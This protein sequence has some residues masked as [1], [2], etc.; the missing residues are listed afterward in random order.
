MSRILRPLLVIAI[1]CLVVGTAARLTLWVVLPGPEHLSHRQLGGG[2]ADL[3]GI[4]IGVWR[5][6]P[7]SF[8]TQAVFGDAR[9]ASLAEARHVFGGAGGLIVGR[10]AKGQLLRYAGPAHLLTFAP[11]RSGK[12]VGAI[13][14]NLLTAPQGVLCIDLKGENA[15]VAGRARAAQGPVH[16]LDP[17]GLTQHAPAAFNPLAALNPA[18][19]DLIE[20]ASEIAEALVHDPPH[21]VGEIHWNEEAKALLAGL[22]LH[23][24]LSRPPA[25]RTL[26]EVRELLTL[27]A[28]RFNALLHIMQLSGHSVVVRAAN[29]HL[30]KAD[31]EAAGVLS[32]AQRHTHFLDSPRMIAA[33]GRSDFSFADLR[34]GASVFLV[35]PPD[36]LDT[37]AR[38][39]RLMIVQAI[40]ALVRE[41]TAADRPVLMLLDEV[42]ALGRLEPLQRAYG[43]LAG[44]G[45]QFWAMLQDVHQLKAHYGEA[46]GTFLAN[47]GLIQVFNVADLE[48]ARWVSATLGG[49]TANYVTYGDS[50]SD[51]GILGPRSTSH[52]TGSAV[53]PR[54]LMTPDEVMRLDRDKLL[55]LSPGDRPL[56]ARKVC[57]YRDPEF[58]GAF[59][60]QA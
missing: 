50:Q 44:Y 59:D 48:T 22:I 17:F 1:W 36:R 2:L 42:A 16:V 29:R 13:I 39:L 5:V 60:A 41:P 58:Q 14:P 6:R 52:S 26:A 35:L 43:L 53:A 9:L 31:R 15:R 21:Q 56:L 24:T 57:Y 32:A 3:V 49:R 38:W 45:V 55:I 28:D 40:S 25:E 10:D 7:R 34:D 54:E 51:P 20:D 4:A 18:S 30:A 11:T 19:P 37:Y 12:G 33:M 46:F 27:P 23:V 47:A 8:P